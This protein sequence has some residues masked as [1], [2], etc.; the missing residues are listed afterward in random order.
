MAKTIELT[1]EKLDALAFSNKLQTLKEEFEIK[2]AK[3]HDLKVQYS[4]E[5][6]KGTTEG[7]VLV[8]KGTNLFHN[9]LREAFAELD[10]FLAHI[11]GAFEAWATNQTPISDL[12]ADDKLSRYEVYDFRI[13]GSE[14]NKAVILIGSKDTPYGVITFQTPKIKLESNN[15][16]YIEELNERLEHLQNEVLLYLSGKKDVD[17]S[18]LTMEFSSTVDDSD[19]DNAKLDD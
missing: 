13:Q 3:L 11:D 1:Q 16:L 17:D 12:E 9:D 10:V 19:F 6:L 7:D 2:S 15:Y 14:E 18:Q 5:L 4:Y 8:R